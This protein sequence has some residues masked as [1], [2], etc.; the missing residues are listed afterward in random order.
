MVGALQEGVI[1][2]LGDKWEQH[3]FTGHYNLT[4][5]GGRALPTTIPVS[6]VT[7]PPCPAA[8]ITAARLL[9]GGIEMGSPTISSA[10]WR[11][12]IS[13]W[14]DTEITCRGYRITRTSRGTVQ[15]RYIKARYGTLRD[16]MQV[17]I[18]E[19]GAQVN[20]QWRDNSELVLDPMEY[21]FKKGRAPGAGSSS[22]SSSQPT[23]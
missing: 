5:V 16:L 7:D 1:E 3:S 2:G 8:T 20:L 23:H 21:V 18:P 14:T 9:A 17:V 11:G 15:G 22:S 13:I 6:W 4:S 10:D 19:T 12:D